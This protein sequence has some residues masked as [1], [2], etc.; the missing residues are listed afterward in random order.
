MGIAFPKYMGGK[1]IDLKASLF[2]KKERALILS[3][4]KVVALNGELLS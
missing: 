4:F 3:E 1:T 2:K